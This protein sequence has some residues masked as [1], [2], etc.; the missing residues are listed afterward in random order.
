MRYEVSP[1][2]ASL[3][4]AFASMASCLHSGPESAG[5]SDAEEF[6]PRRAPA[7][8]TGLVGVTGASSIARTTALAPRSRNGIGGYQYDPDN[9]LTSRSDAAGGSDASCG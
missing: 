6:G 7:P 4:G 5:C 1:Q 9:R 8:A 2:P 3:G